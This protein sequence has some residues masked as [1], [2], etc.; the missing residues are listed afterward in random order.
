MST[1]TNSPYDYVKNTHMRLIVMLAVGSFLL[2]SIS[3][4]CLFSFLFWQNW[5]IRN[6]VESVNEEA[7]E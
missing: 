7:F 5:D 3:M 6:N 4:I 1:K 2:F